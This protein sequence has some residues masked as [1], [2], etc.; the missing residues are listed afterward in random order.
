V[1]PVTG[2]IRDGV[3]QVVCLT[4]GSGCGLPLRLC[5]RDQVAP[6]L[7]TA[8]TRTLVAGDDEG[9]YGWLAVNYLLGKLGKPVPQTVAMMD[10]GGGSMQMAYAVEDSVAAEAPLGY[11]RPV[12]YAGYTYN[13]YVKSYPGAWCQCSPRPPPCP[14]QWGDWQLRLSRA[15]HGSSLA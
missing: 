8:S 2:G 4:R 12:T 14:G 3:V 7:L 1:L 13:L 5:V 11:V 6:R 15:P 10:M 9:V